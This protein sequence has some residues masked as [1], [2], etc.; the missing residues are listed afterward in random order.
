MEPLAIIFQPHFNTLVSASKFTNQAKNNLIVFYSFTPLLFTLLDFLF[1]KIC[2]EKRG[3]AEFNFLFI[4]NVT[5]PFQLFHSIRQLYFCLFT[6]VFT[7]HNL[8]KAS[9]GKFF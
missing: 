3:C 2:Q 5:F 1:I 6:L 7:S 9:S 8:N 4:F